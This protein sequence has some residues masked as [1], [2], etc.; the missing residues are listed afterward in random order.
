VQLN[1]AEISELWNNDN[2]LAYE[3][4]SG[5]GAL[6]WDPDFPIGTWPEGSWPEGSYPLSR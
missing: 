3:D 4:F 1:P 5:G 2:G 6:P